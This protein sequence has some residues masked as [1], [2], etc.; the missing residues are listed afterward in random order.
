MRNLL[1]H[2]KRLR[3]HPA[4]SSLHWHSIYAV[5]G[6]SVTIGL[7]GLA[8]PIYTLQIYDRVL[9]SRSVDTLL[10][11]TLGIVIVMAI[12]TALDALRN[13]ALVRVCNR[14]EIDTST[15]ALES[16][17]Q[18]AAQGGGGS[19]QVLRDIGSVRQ[20]IGG[21]Q[22][23]VL[24]FEMPFA[25]IYLVVVFLIQPWL[26]VAMIFGGALLLTLAILTELGTTE[27]LKEANQSIIQSHA[28]A[29]A[30]IQNAEV[31]E[32][33][34]MRHALLQRWFRES[35]RGM[36]LASATGDQISWF[37][38]GSRGLR[39]GINVLMSGL[40]AYLAIRNE[41][42]IGGMIAANILAARG[43]APIEQVIGGWKQMVGTLQ[44]L[45]R[46][47]KL[48]EKHAA[49]GEPI[50]LP[51]PTG[52][53]SVEQLVFVPP[54]AE[55]P[56]LK[57]VSLQAKAGSI[58]AVIG[59]SG[60]GKTTLAKLIAGVWTPRSG[61]VRLDGADV[62]QWNRRHFG[63]YVGYLPQDIEL[64]A[65]SVR[66]NIARFRE[67]AKDED[68]IAAAQAAAAH[69]MILRLPKGYETDIG[70]GGATLSGGQRQ[71]V[72][73]ARALFGRP[74]LVI[75]DEPN[76]FLDTEGE[77]AL[78]T[79]LRGVRAGGGT[80]ILITHRLPIAEIADQMA[81]LMEGQIRKVGTTAEVLAAMRPNP[82]MH[83]AKPAATA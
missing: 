37:G 11:L 3:G 29:D 81:V 28:R 61:V 5:A 23:L 76:A 77:E 17:V 50:E 18:A 36:A 78:V 32:A 66:D 56:T 27:R 30:I 57:G 33:M 9:I 54:G 64:F 41:I 72:G 12:S 13:Q 79:A 42:T 70:P 2:L 65:G 51:E 15:R 4:L 40:G 25:L 47:Q 63:R 82:P 38:A 10:L 19:A 22:G 39:L 6:I 7:L 46:L 62:C 49:A 59:P 44:S 24:L 67:D 34:G 21:A 68:I 60:S 35:G 58:L 83:L 1:E 14:Y 43:L 8:L 48:L 45:E 16:V 73:L 80:V 75:L 55:H 20:F 26:A 31:V 53:V 69:D 52:A 71:R 74:K